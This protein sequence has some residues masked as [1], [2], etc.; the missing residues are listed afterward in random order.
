ML[1]GNSNMTSPDAHFHTLQA[2]D[3]TKAALF[4]ERYDKAIADPATKLK[5]H[6]VSHYLA[7]GALGLDLR[8]YATGSP[9]SKKLRTE[10]TAYQL[11]MLDD[12]MQESPHARISRVVQAARPSKPPWW[13]ATVRLRQNLAI[14]KSLD[15]LK[16]QHSR[17]LFQAW[18]FLAHRNPSS[19]VQWNLIPKRVGTKPFLQMVYRLGQENRTDWSSLRILSGRESGVDIG[20]LR[21]LA[22]DHTLWE[23]LFKRVCKP[24][25]FFTIG[26]KYSALSAL[27]TLGQDG[28]PGLPQPTFDTTVC[29]QVVHLNPTAKRQPDTAA[30]QVERAM[31]LPAMVQVY[32]VIQASDIND[33]CPILHVRPHDMPAVK[34]MMDFAG[35]SSLRTW[36]P[37]FRQW[38]LASSTSGN[39]GECD[40]V[41]PILV[42]RKTWRYLYIV[43]LE[44]VNL[45]CLCYVWYQ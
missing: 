25:L 15:E 11:C 32:Q 14:C 37:D 23:D 16:P 29:F 42:N 31:K 30:V 12:S 33:P 35:H 5:V 45:L 8:A 9:M 18:K 1:F 2:D 26:R 17:A 43:L 13:S 7:S 24:G 38:T 44:C 28:A 19:H 40:I 10:I 34:D 22:Q 27:D 41:D 39:T 3:R 6:R 36:L 21:K 20:S 4:V